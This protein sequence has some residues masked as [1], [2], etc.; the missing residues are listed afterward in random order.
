MALLYLL[1]NITLRHLGYHKGRTLLSLIGIALGVAVFISIQIAIHTAIESFNSSVDHVSG[2]ANLQIT[3]FGRGFPEEAFLRVKKISGIK[4][5][6]PVIQFVSK[7]DEPIGEPLYL[8]GI[9]IFSDQQFRDYRFDE[10]KE[11]DL[12]FLKD[13]QAIAITEKLAGRHGLKKGSA[14]PLIFGSKKVVLTITDLLKMEG[15][16]KSLEGNFGLMDIASAQEALE[17]VGLIDRIDLIVE[18]SRDLNEVERE[19]KRVI[20][21]GTEI[22]R[23]ETRSGQ[24]E[25]MVSAFHLNLTALSFISIVVGMFLIYN[26]ISTSVIQRRREIG[27]LRSIGVTRS[28]VL[29]LMICEAGLIGMLGSLVGIGV[30]IGLA[31]I[32]L[33][34]VSR[35]ITALYI[36]VKAE[37]L[38]IS[39]LILLEGFGLGLLASVLSAIGPAKE[40]SKIAPREALALGTLETKVKIRLGRFGLIG[41]ILLLLSFF[42]AL[43][44]PIY[45]RPLFGF[46]SA[47]LIVIGVSFLIPFIT[48]FLNR[49]L[50][51]LL[52]LLLGVEGRLASRYIQDSMARTVI[53][54]AALMTALSMLISI[55]IMILSF[56]KTVDLW[57]EQSLNGDVFIFPG[58]YSHTGYS[59]LLPIEV[60]KALPNLPGVKAVDS[61]RALEV[62]YRGQPTVIAAVNGKVFQNMK[63]IRFIRGNSPE[64]LKQFADGKS[65]LV[66]ESFSL[67]HQVEGGDR[68]RINTPQGEKEFLVSGVFYDYTTDWGLI[69]MEKKLF[70][71]LWNDETFHSAGIYLKEGVSIEAFKEMIR[72]R[73]SKPYQ[74]FLVSHREL[75]HEILKIF[76]QTFTITYSLELIAIFVA[77]LG[78]INSLNALI[79]ERKRDIGIFRAVGAFRKQVEKTVLTEAGIIGFFSLVLGLFCGFL[80]SLLLIY[81]INKQSFGWTI[82][83]SI[84]LW[85]LME[86]GLVVMVTSIGAGIIPARRAARMNVVEPLRME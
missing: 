57:V 31:K 63:V 68:I 12:R 82:Q 10:S 15:P 16:A 74:L 56:R 41:I 79:I 29:S 32:M 11:E 51:P 7:I 28:Q 38:A 26:A 25:K 48:H 73:Y 9:D 23:P 37:H 50:A 3:S 83:L 66:T 78:I 62:E 81:V 54:I 80:L 71:S 72:E 77:I 8:L 52:R 45:Q 2:K 17:K 19:L 55:S 49:L 4:A 18:K 85:S 6:T 39:P 59:A 34:F 40:A 69:L 43:Q 60:S 24:I 86:F 65:I 84:P 47:L 13:P 22:R 64:I 27:I 70:Q 1:R 67:R 46:L 5:A 42:F 21:P 53:T 75:R 44:K 36:L 61:F 76:D 20:P 14:L 35:T 30:G 58:S 33:Y